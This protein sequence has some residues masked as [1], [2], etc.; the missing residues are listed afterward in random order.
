MPKNL[1]KHY[2][3]WVFAKAQ[4]GFMPKNRILEMALVNMELHAGFDYR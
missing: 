4:Y 2:T 3:V 1:K